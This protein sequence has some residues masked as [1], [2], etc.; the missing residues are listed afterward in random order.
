MGGLK[1]P[2]RNQFFSGCAGRD[3]PPVAQLCPM[4]LASEHGPDCPI[5]PRAPKA[6]R[7]QKPEVLVPLLLPA[8][9]DAGLPVEVA[10]L[11]PRGRDKSITHSDNIQKSFVL[12]DLQDEV[13]VMLRERLKP[14]ASSRAN[15]HILRQ[16]HWGH[17]MLWRQ[18]QETSPQR[19]IIPL[20]PRIRPLF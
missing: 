7:M 10:T 13:I 12:K 15:I 5:Q 14:S 11:A 2:P 6:P 19:S 17:Q 3:R 16:R 18:V 20:R 8:S 1:S 9:W 4:R